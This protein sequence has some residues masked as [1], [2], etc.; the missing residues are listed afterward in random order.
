[1]IELP[2]QALVVAGSF[3]VACVE[4][5]VKTSLLW[6]FCLLIVLGWLEMKEISLVSSGGMLLLVVQELG[7]LLLRG[8]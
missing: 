1:L 5:F 8:Q 3:H 7:A 6:C 4:F 2:G